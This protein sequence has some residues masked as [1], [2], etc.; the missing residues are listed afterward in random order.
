VQLVDVLPAITEMAG[1]PPP[2]GIQGD[3]PSHVKHPIIAEV[4]PLPPFAT[5]GESRAIIELPYKLLWNSK[6]GRSLFNIQDDPGET[7]NLLESEGPRAER[8]LGRL[9]AYL[10][11]LPRPGAAG[12]QRTLD[13]ETQESLKSLG[14]VK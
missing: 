8:M 6:A 10:E 3:P 13:K 14:Y 2:P 12:P 1:I 7:R 11:R 5:T 4:Y 9:K